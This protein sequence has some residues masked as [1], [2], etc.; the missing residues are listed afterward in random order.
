MTE[1]TLFITNSFQEL[2]PEGHTNDTGNVKNVK[3]LE[4]FNVNKQHGEQGVISQKAIFFITI[5]VGTSNPTKWLVI[6]D[7]ALLQSVDVA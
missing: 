3:N 5:A 1:Y 4:T 6:F 7:L 2:F